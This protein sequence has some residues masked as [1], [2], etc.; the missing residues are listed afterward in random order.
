MVNMET[1]NDIF[2]AARKTLRAAGVEAS[3]LEARLIISR[4]TG[5][6]REEL[7]QSSRL[8]LTDPSVKQAVYEMLTRRLK[9]EPI[10]YILGEWEFFSLPFV[11]NESVLIP[12]V[13]TELLADEAIRLTKRHGEKSRVLDLCT[14]S[15]CIGIAIAANVPDCRVVLVDNSPPAL[16]LCRANA[17]R[18]VRN[19]TTIDADAMAPPPK[20][21]GMLD[22]MVSN[23]PYIPT[24]D[25]I[26]LDD[27]V[28]F[29]E[30]V[31]ALDGGEDGFDFFRA[32]TANWRAVLKPG[33]H[34]LFECGINQAETLRG[35]MEEN[36]FTDIRTLTDT[37]GIE[38][39]VIGRY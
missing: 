17:M 33:G 4:A 25:L 28:R 10:A 12:R 37:L 39:V 14:G 6:S 20:L 7:L 27:S 13:D 19:T 26:T 32:I 31:H 11:V 2:L 1:Y 34:M 3:D 8:F 30:P 16:K 15:G 35:I 36:G 9:G 5:K 24:A 23:P 18:L 21:L 22:V 38:R 29:Y